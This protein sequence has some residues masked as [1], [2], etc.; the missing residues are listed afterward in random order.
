[1]YSDAPRPSAAGATT[2]RRWVTVLFADLVGFT[3][4]AERLDPEDLRELQTAYFAAIT[5]P[6]AAY[7]GCIE[8]Y[9]GDAVLAVFGAPR[10][11]E[12]DA[13]RGARA[14]LAMQEALAA[15]N[16]R[17]AH[18]P[19]L[20]MRIGLQT[21]L[22]VAMVEPA[23]G[24]VITGE[25]VT[26]AARLQDAAPPG[27]ILIGGETQRRIA[28]AFETIPLGPIAVRGRAEPV[29]AFRLMA[30]RLAAAYPH[31]P[32]MRSPLVGRQIELNA[33]VAAIGRLTEGCGGIVTITGEAGIGKSRLMAEARRA[34]PVQRIMTHALQPIQW[35]EG[36]CFSYTAAAYQ[37]WRDLLR[38]A[39]KLPADATAETAA[40]AL[41]A[42]VAEL[43]P[44]RCVELYPP[45]ARLLVLPVAA[46]DSPGRGG[47]APRLSGRRPEQERKD[48]IERDQA[49]IHRSA[50]AQ[51]QIF[52]AVRA[53]IVGL[54][55]CAPLALVC[56]DLHWADP[57]SIE[58]IE[59]LLP[60]V[61]EIP[62]LLTCV[63]RPQPD[64][65]A[66]RLRELAAEKYGPRH[67]D[68]PLLPLPPDACAA[69]IANLL[70]AW[71]PARPGEGA[72]RTS[73]ALQRPRLVA[74]D[75]LDRIQ[76]QAEGNP[77]FVEE[78]V[79]ALAGCGALAHDA[80][81]GVW[82]ATL[83]AAGIA[84]P[85]TIN[86]ILTARIDDLP[87][88]TR[89]VVRLAA[90]IGRIFPHRLLAAIAGDGPDLDAHLR[91]LHGQELIQ[92]RD[93]TPE[94]EFIF[95]HELTREAA[96]EGL[97][98]SERR[99]AHRAVAET[100]ER[101]PATLGDRQPGLLAH[102][103][104][105]AEAPDKAVEW[106]LQAG[107]QARLAYAREE[108]IGF[109]ERALALQRAAGDDEAAARTLMRMGL[110]HNAA[111]DYPRAEAASNAGFALWRQA[112]ARPPTTADLPDAGPPQTLR[113]SWYPWATVEALQSR[114]APIQLQLF[115]G[116]V[117]ETPALEVV[118]AVAEGWDVSPD[119]RT[120]TFHL[121]P[122]ARWSDGAPV[123]AA[124]FLAG[125]RRTLHQDMPDE[126]ALL[127]DD[128]RGARAYHR[129][130]LTNP[131][132]LGIHPRGPHTLVVELERP[133]AYFLHILALPVAMPVPG[134]L[135]NLKIAPPDAPGASQAPG[136][137][138]H[139]VGNGPFVVEAVRPG[140]IL[141]LARN[142]S[143]SG[144]FTGNI[145]RVEINQRFAANEWEAMIEMFRSG[146]Y[147][148]CGIWNF[149]PE[150]HAA[151]RS[152]HT[153]GY[154]VAPSLSVGA[155]IFNVTQ[156]PFDDWRVRWAF[157]R[158][159][160]VCDLIWRVNEG[161]ISPGTGG[162][163]PPGMPGH[164]PGLAPAFD[165]AEARRLLAAAGYR[166]GADLPLT[167]ILG[168]DSPAAHY[169]SV[170]FRGQLRDNLGITVER[171]NPGPTEHDRILRTATTPPANLMWLGV[172]ARYPDPD[173]LLR[174]M[175]E[176]VW[177]MVGRRDAEFDR[178]VEEARGL[179]DHEA[180]LALYRQADA[181]LVREAYVW[182]HL[183]A[184]THLLL[185][186]WVKRYPVSPL[187]MSFWKDVVIAPH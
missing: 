4:L 182:P 162:W 122:D 87:A 161:R 171:R 101:Q 2:D 29:D 73:S 158:G 54:A 113:L 86:G 148:V 76:A 111:F 74:Q 57:S 106:L 34:V 25:A 11:H 39:L 50:P 3:A 75:L 88:A 98:K 110:A 45:L 103:W 115:A 47:G 92:P 118:P 135:T 181:I 177:R 36:R 184:R 108:A 41:W 165:L 64:H 151:A 157:Q 155:W 150:A 179:R 153:G 152:W 66:A 52:D 5:P 154:L 96:Y 127:L 69:L 123:V 117:E 134:H 90:V 72:G 12:D 95:K 85:A 83:A 159:V 145:G 59:Q 40:R 17:H 149:P 176:R 38:S 160:D 55:R 26:L 65:R 175:S 89:R 183:Y 174:V 51:R 116:L 109:Y 56:E 142:P 63:A 146:G 107:D 126:T 94:R 24:F 164:S 163:V 99:A 138:E 20:A 172:A 79:R 129:G 9:I 22:V 140:E 121:R 147:D 35:L 187:P 77:F 60:L 167:R 23:G 37:L 68:I 30:P 143:Y 166:D 178:L 93:Q 42:W 14:A 137:R 21:G 8:K 114:A 131:D 173:S 81:T 7:G 170:V 46:T 91:T 80:A 144:R 180:R 112:M 13:E 28:G 18:S 124:D 48:R 10:A 169:Y 58:L 1:M 70:E 97:L 53:V 67:T 136:A 15:L 125:W 132:D 43:R 168:E 133:A 130:E 16:E 139:W 82:H 185:Q 71:S 128:I 19:P 61:A 44:D 119:G 6:I 33:L 27:A 62:L 84:R 102:H 32:P 104:E 156:P 141:T 105:R 78:L 100:L 120:Y 31:P 49:D 186:P